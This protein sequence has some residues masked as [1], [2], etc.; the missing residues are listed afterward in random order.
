MAWW[1]PPK[2]T[3]TIRIHHIGWVDTTGQPHGT[4]DIPSHHLRLDNHTIETTLADHLVPEHYPTL[5]TLLTAHQLPPKELNDEVRL[6]I[7]GHTISEVDLLTRCGLNVVGGI[8]AQLLGRGPQATI[9]LEQTLSRPV[10]TAVLT[11]ARHHLT[12]FATAKPSEL[13]NSG[14]QPQPDDRWQLILTQP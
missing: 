5:P 10:R 13:F 8:S 14:W 11:T 3:A 4:I 1:R 6:I 9:L 12:R 2:P 7:D